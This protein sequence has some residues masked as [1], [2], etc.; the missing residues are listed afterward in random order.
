ML[1]HSCQVQRHP[2]AA[3]GL[4]L[5]ET[6]S[7][8][9]ET[10]LRVEHIPRCVWEPAAGRGAIT[11]VLQQHGHRVIG[12]DICD[13]GSDTK[14][15]FVA[16]FLTCTRLPPDWRRLRV[17]IESVLERHHDVSAAIDELVGALDDE[18]EERV[19]DRVEDLRQQVEQGENQ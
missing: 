15:D 13:Y 12:S 1:D 19:R 5:Y 10:L 7:C 3:R 11:R 4:D 17:L 6:P 16:D 9:V 14:L 2:L 8:A 18:I